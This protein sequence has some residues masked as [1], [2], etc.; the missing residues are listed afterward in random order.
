MDRKRWLGERVLQ[1][2]NGQDLATDWIGEEQGKVRISRGGA[3]Q[4]GFSR[5]CLVQEASKEEHHMLS[6]PPNLF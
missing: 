4:A 3:S 5:T 6:R 1:S 2:L